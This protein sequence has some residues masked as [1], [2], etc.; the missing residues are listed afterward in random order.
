MPM[1]SAVI[2]AALLAVA[3]IAWAEEPKTDATPPQNALQ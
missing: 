3:T 1:R 2:A